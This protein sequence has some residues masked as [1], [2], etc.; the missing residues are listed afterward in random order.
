[1]SVR[2]RHTREHTA[3]RRSHHALKPAQLV[4]CDHCQARKQSHRVCMSCGYYKGRATIDIVGKQK[5][6]AT[7]KAGKT[8]PENKEKVT[9]NAAKGD[10]K[11]KA[12]NAQAAS[13]PKTKT[14]Q[15]TV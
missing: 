6:K 14:R 15:K 12:A 2:M 3:N 10:T 11:A 8:S 13:A 5:A 9:T 4:V 1:M 7:A